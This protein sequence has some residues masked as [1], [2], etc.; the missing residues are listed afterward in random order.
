[1]DR[2]QTPTPVGTG[3]RPD[4]K[5]ALQRDAISF[6]PFRLHVAQ[7]L[8]LKDGKPVRLGSRSLDILAV[9]L[10]RSGELVSKDELIDR[11]WPGIFVGEGN[12]RV[13][14][15]TLRK[16]LDDGEE[17]S[18]YIVNVPGRGYR[19]VA[20]I[21]HSEA[22]AAPPPIVAESIHHLPSLPGAV[23]GRTGVIDSITAQIP[24]RRCI[25]VVGIG[26]IGKT[27]VAMSVAENLMQAYKNSVH[28]VDL[29]PLA[30]PQLVPG[31]LASEVGLAVTS[32]NP[33]PAL[34]AHF[35]DKSM[36][37]VLDSC[38]HVIEAAAALTG[39]V[40]A[41]APG[42]HILATSR[43][44]LRVEG[45]HVQR[46]TPLESPPGL[47]VIGAAESLKFSAVQLFVR[48]AA[49][50]LDDF[51]LTDRNAPI[52]AEICRKLDGIPLAI[53]MVAARVDT[54]TLQELAARL[55]DRFSLLNRGR[56][57]ALPRHQTLRALLDWSYE[58]LPHIEQAVLRRLAVFP[59]AFTMESA[60][61]VAAG[62]DVAE[63]SVEDCIANLVSKSLV[64]AHVLQEKA[65][66]RLLDTTHA[67]ALTKLTESGEYDA[68]ARRHAAYYR[69]LL[70][71]IGD[72]ADDKVFAYK[73][74]I[75]NIRAALNWAFVPAGD[76]SI[77]VTLAAAS[78][79]IW[80]EMSLLNECQGW[81]K[82][83]ID[84][85]EVSDRGTR[86]EM[87]LQ[88]AF[89]ISLMF[90]QGMSGRA[91]EALTIAIRLAERFQDHDYQLQALN[92]LARFYNLVENFNGG[93]ACGRQAESIARTTGNPRSVSMANCVLA[94]SLF[95][96]GQNS[97]ALVH[98]QR[99][100][101][102]VTPIERQ[103]YI[104]RSGVDYSIWADSIVT[105]VLWTQGL[106][107]Q[108]ARTARDV[109]S[110][111]R[112]H[113]HAVSLS[114]ALT[115][116]G[117]HISLRL[118]DFD[119]AERSIAEL[120]DH[121]GKNGLDSYFAC[122]LGFEGW[123]QADRGN[124]DSGVQ[125]LRASL[126]GLRKAQ[127]EHHYTRFLSRLAEV[128]GEAGYLEDS[129]A[130]IDETLQRIERNDVLWLLPEALRIKAMIVLL[131]NK[132]DEKKAEHLFERSLDLARRQ[133]AL[134]W[135][136]RTAMSFSLL[137]SAQGRAPEAHDLLKAVYA[138]FTEGFHAR[139]L[140]RA[141][142]LI[143][144]WAVAAR[145]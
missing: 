39:Q 115:W 30:D 141:K 138:K 106:F 134:S 124:P 43:E 130:A 45:E 137:R 82:K 108:S 51:E 22:I 58:F 28:F 127:Y 50:C 86:R 54:F 142:S 100:H 5:A 73:S 70:E 118:G 76:C 128:L 35:K 56:R 17:G 110:N 102:G 103:E 7:Q 12:L 24:R 44:P 136:L 38:D 31:T 111:A 57:T 49:A 92:C 93:L 55:D 10:E 21:A 46:L 144:E 143:D 27:R 29:A 95:Y 113:G 2:K 133:Q 135:E 84:F 88:T 121:A 145:S 59:G 65:S 75:A 123:L 79:P 125:L 129:M 63:S 1:M 74:E 69:D 131:P 25:T 6:G 34:I 140:K 120:K 139:K 37:L 132:R 13:H 61:A 104:V 67:Y 91:R 94:A 107:D 16:T 78:V 23:V 72:S 66:Y 116:A 60:S 47:D 53:E 80:L 126:E 62:A 8:L 101:R 11:V 105:N 26:G 32:A 15:A 77:A 9:L 19:F 68:I 64:V 90:S 36:L 99:V 20:D 71:A 18:R 87:Q 112:A 33:L 14:I 98:A 122:G 3:S 42:V 119:A 40:L 96:L 97:E 117:C 109:V 52:V 83:A 81:M 48:R 89:G 4:S 85:L 41:G 114:H